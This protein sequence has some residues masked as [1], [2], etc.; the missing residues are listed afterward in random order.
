LASEQ[1]LLDK[2]NGSEKG[3]GEDG[4]VSRKKDDKLRQSKFVTVPINKDFH[5]RILN[6]I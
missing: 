3:G 2:A 1:R 5:E 4:D 6:C